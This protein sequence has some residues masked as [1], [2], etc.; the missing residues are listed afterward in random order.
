MDFSD[1]T[2]ERV[3]LLP[4]PAPPMNHV[5]LG[6]GEEGEGGMRTGRDRKHLGLQGLSGSREAAEFLAATSGASLAT[7]V[8]AGM[9]GRAVH[10]CQSSI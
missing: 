7:R 4:G 2:R 9:C 6:A 1:Q 3:L 8:V 10:W 5:G